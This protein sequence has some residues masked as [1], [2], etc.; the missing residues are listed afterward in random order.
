MIPPMVAWEAVNIKNKETQK[1]KSR[2]IEEH[3]NDVWTM[4]ETKR[5]V[6]FH[7][8]IRWR[9]GVSASAVVLFYFVT[10]VAGL[11][12]RDL[13]RKWP[14]LMHYWYEKEKIFL[15]SPYRATKYNPTTL[16]T[17]VA[18]T[19]FF[20]VIFE[21]TMYHIA[22]YHE[23]VLNMEYCNA[24]NQ[25]DVLKR[26]YLRE[27]GHFADVL[28]FSYW[29][30]PI[31]EWENLTFAISWS[32]IDV[33]IVNISIGLTTRFKQLN[34]RINN[35]QNLNLMEDQWLHLRKQHGAL[36]D[37]VLEVN[38]HVSSLILL[39]CG[40][41]LYFIVVY[42]FKSFTPSDSIYDDIHFYTV[43]FLII[44]RTMITLYA[45]STIN[46]ASKGILNTLRKVPQKSWNF[47]VQRF[48]DQ[49]EAQTVALT[50]KNMFKLTRKM[51]LA[52]T[53]TV[54]TFEIALLDQ[55]QSEPSNIGACHATF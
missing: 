44:L 51:I 12:L 43:V 48:I 35:I 31:L 14:K 19:I 8:S 50:G 2:I 25:S 5:I 46:D 53:G 37:L 7:E 21:H 28:P 16:M 27:R 34:N 40:N 38:N 1:S 41:N 20:I 49:I 11:L 9:F 42:I 26:L 54:V 52:F 13:A 6:T 10:I 36:T 39:S 4:M 30:V 33:I 3:F 24:T 18:I 17:F 45:T 15:K 32:Y 29:I 22:S 55:I 47:E 23:T